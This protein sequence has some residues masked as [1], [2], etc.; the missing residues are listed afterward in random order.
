[1]VE[2]I[3]LFLPFYLGHVNCYL[4]KTADGFVLID[5]GGTNQRQ[6]LLRQLASCQCSPGKLRLIILTHGDFDHSGNAAYLREHFG[7]R[8]AMSPLDQGMI[9]QRDLTYNRKGT[10]H[11]AKPFLP[12]IYVF[13]KSDQF[14]PDLLLYDGTDLTSEGFSATV[15]SIPGHTKGSVAVLT[16][17]G[18]LFCGDLLVCRNRV[19]MN[20]LLDDREDAIA[21]IRK[22]RN[23]PAHMVYPG[24]GKPF[25][26]ND[27]TK[28]HF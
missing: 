12:W 20:T 27:F 16:I 15:Y 2:R 1:M 19:V 28:E 24:H 6:K 4:I 14:I 11:F 21:S 5:T 8:I 7:G 10:P 9:E 17:G 26:M 22:L 23:L 3:S 25:P 18:D 13:R